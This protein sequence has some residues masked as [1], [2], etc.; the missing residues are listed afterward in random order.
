MYP[1]LGRG[2]I[3]AYGS[4]TGLTLADQKAV[5][6]VDVDEKET[7]EFKEKLQQWKK[8]GPEKG[9]KFR[10][11]YK[12]PEDV[13]QEKG[14]SSSNK[15]SGSGPVTATSA[16][17]KMSQVRKRRTKIRKITKNKN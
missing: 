16:G 6:K 7:K 13:I 4:E 17:N 3:G 12:T 5:K 8:H 1:L 15:K 9:K 2:A 11:F 14:S 10:Y